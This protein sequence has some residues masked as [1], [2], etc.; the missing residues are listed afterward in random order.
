MFKNG[1]YLLAAL[2]LKTLFAR[3]SLTLFLLLLTLLD[4]RRHQVHV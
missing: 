1:C 3:L 2:Y 4:I